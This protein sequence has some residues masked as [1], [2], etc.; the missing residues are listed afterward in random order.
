L[1]SD[2]TSEFPNSQI[3]GVL[4]NTYSNLTTFQKLSEKDQESLKSLVVNL[5]IA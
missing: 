4:P 2:I 3:L 1:P 5:N